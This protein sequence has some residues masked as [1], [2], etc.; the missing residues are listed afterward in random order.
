MLRPSFSIVT[1][2]SSCNKISH[3]GQYVLTAKISIGRLTND[4]EI[5]YF[6]ISSI[7]DPFADIQTNEVDNANKAASPIVRYRFFS[8]CNLFLYP[9]LLGHNRIERI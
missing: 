1:E 5:G 6:A 9:Y 4:R 7:S 3:R 2:A 8:N